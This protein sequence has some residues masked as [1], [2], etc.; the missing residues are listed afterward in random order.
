MTTH[1]IEKYLEVVK[2]ELDWMGVQAS[3]TEDQK[4]KDDPMNWSIHLIDF[5]DDFRHFAS[6]A[7][8]WFL[9]SCYRNNLYLFGISERDYA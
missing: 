6:P 5:V 4:I 7:G 8:E 3:Q 9:R 1:E 2:D